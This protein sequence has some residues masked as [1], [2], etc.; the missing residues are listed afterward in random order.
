MGQLFDFLDFDAD[1]D[2]D[3]DIFGLPVSPL[4]PIIIMSFITTFGGIGI[5]MTNKGVSSITSFAIGLIFGIVVSTILYKF[6]V[7]PLYK[8]QNTSAISKEE[9]IGHIGKAKESI[10]GNGFGSITYVVNGNTYS[11]PAKSID[12][13]NIYK[14]EEVKIVSIEK[15]IFYVVRA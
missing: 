10:I 8:A 3:G 7:V 14:G 1:I 4:K 12:S 9:L 11:A 13:T 15:N 5:I 2:M 6:V